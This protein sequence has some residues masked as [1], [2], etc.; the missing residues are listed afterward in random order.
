[1]KAMQKATTEVMNENARKDPQFKEVYTAWKA[2][3]DDRH[4]GMSVNDDGA[5][6]FLYANRD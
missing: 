2:F 3:R 4:L 5:E 1:M 6:R